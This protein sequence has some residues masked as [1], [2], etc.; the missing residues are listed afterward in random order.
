MRFPYILAT[1][2]RHSP[3]KLSD[4]LA[5]WLTGC[6]TDCLNDWLSVWLADWLAVW[7]TDCLTGWLTGC[8]TDWLAV[9]LTVWLTGCLSDWL[10]DQPTNRPTNQPPN[11]Y[12]AMPCTEASLTVACR[13]RSIHRLLWY[14][15]SVLHTCRLCSLHCLYC[16][17]HMEFYHLGT[18]C[19]LISINAPAARKHLAPCMKHGRYIDRI[20]LKMF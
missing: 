10:T 4:W 3:T 15:G 16:R 7:L 8:L 17:H 18:E 2:L 6:L 9:W 12:V 19:S 5:I 20:R 1:D 13:H 14:R 11:S